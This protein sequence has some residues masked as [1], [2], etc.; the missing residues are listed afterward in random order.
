MNKKI[1]F[2]VFADFHY[3]RGMYPVNVEELEKILERAEKN[4]TDFI[5]HCGDLCNDYKGSLELLNAYLNNRYEKR[6][7]GIY[8]NHELE[9]YNS[10]EYVTTKLTNDENVVWGTKDGNIGDGKIAYYYFD[11]KGFRIV[12]TDTNYSYNEQEEIWEH[13][14]YASF[15]P[16]AENIKGNSLGP[17]Q[18]AWLE[19][20]LYDAAKKGLHCIVFSHD[21]FSG[22]WG[23]SP[24]TESVKK[25]FSKTNLINKGTVVMAINGHYHRNH[26]AKQDGIVY[27][28]VNTACNGEW[29]IDG[30]THYFEE[31]TYEFTDY[32]DRGEPI[33]KQMLP[34]NDAWMSPRSWYFEEPLNAVITVED[35]GHIIIDGMKTKW[36]YDIL[37]DNKELK[38]EIT[39]AEFFE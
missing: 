5:I 18:L 26:V 20:V 10:M 12:C 35:D 27:L 24:D 37:P 4:N 15:G 32:N 22:I 14:R 36:R 28:D 19:N 1:K 6:V 3:K 8:G 9:S 16:P 23:S 31:H 39:S 21:G 2:S 34:L 29:L 25:I 7:Y 13:N 33:G 17:D 11:I 30:Q 38:P